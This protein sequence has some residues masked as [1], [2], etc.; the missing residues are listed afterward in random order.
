[1]E[2]S[3]LTTQELK[4]RLQ[5]LSQR[6]ASLD[7]HL[8]LLCEYKPAQISDESELLKREHAMHQLR[9]QVNADIEDMGTLVS[10]FGN[11]MRGH[12]ELIEEWTKLGKLFQVMQTKAV[13]TSQSFLKTARKLSLQPF[14]EAKPEEVSR[15]PAP[16]VEQYEAFLS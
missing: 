10:H 14:I 7:A 5:Y 16:Q 12:P 11:L 15:R 8:G 13:E 9:I 3:G 4:Q 1:M 2:E 6:L